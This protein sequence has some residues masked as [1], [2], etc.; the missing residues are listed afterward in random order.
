MSGNGTASSSG[1]SG[2]ATTTSSVVSAVVN[3]TIEVLVDALNGT[4]AATAAAPTEEAAAAPDAAAPADDAAV[5]VAPPS[6]P[7][8]NNPALLSYFA[9]GVSSMFI[10]AV[11]CVARGTASMP[12]RMRWLCLVV[13]G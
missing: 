11:I 12:R 10:F 2:N 1:T 5:D 4:T 7:V 3:A 13:D 9:I 8:D 6:G